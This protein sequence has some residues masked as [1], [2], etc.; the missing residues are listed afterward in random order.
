MKI[1]CIHPLAWIVLL[2]CSFMGCNNAVYDDLGD[3]PQGIDFRFYSRTPCDLSPG[4]P[5]DIRQ[6]RVFAF[7]EKEI[8]VDEF[9]DKEVSLSANYSL[10]VLFN[11]TG[12]F[13]F[14][15]WGGTAVSE[16]E[17]SAFQRGV[18]TKNDML[19]SLRQ[20]D[21]GTFPVPKSLYFGQ[22]DTFLNVSGKEDMGTIYEQVKFNM[23]ELTNRIHFTL[24][25][26]PSTGDFGIFISD[27]NGKYDFEGRIV[28]DERF[29]YTSAVRHEGDVFK[30]DFI[31][32]KLE[33]KRDTRVSV[34]DMKTGRVIYTANLVDDLIMYRGDSGNPPYSLE[35][36]HDFDIDITLRY[37]EEAW[38]LIK[39]IVNDW[40]VV[41]RP[42]ILD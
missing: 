11:H 12:K 25:G 24:R 32:M 22:T 34:V 30:S 20:N 26:L 35:C 33:E 16:C 15:A 27:D 7:D 18:T 4:Y 37:E 8:L 41:T 9:S 3:C 21:D 28:P 31:L 39:A 5:S 36:D 2:A 1:E 14:V 38:M 29:D 17:F 6:V 23:Q 10:S 40:N 13:T 42:V 19:L